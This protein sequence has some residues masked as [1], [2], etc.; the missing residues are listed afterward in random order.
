VPAAPVVIEDASGYHGEAERAFAPES[1][2]ELA[3]LLA[4]ASH[5]KIPVTVAGALTGVAGGAA[6]RGGWSISTS[7]LRHLD[8]RPGLAVVAAGV[9]LADLHAAASATGQI[10]GP[11][12]T[13]TTASLGGNAA[14]NASGSRSFRY[15]DTRRNTLAL[16]V[17]T[18]GGRP[19]EFRRGEPID[20]PVRSIPAPRTTKHAAGFPLA[21]GMDWVDLFIGSEGSLGVITALEVRLEPKPP[22]LLSGVVFF[23]TEEH[24]LD[25]VDLWRGVE[26]LRM[27][28]FLDAASL[29]MLETPAGAALLIE[30]E[31]EDEDGPEVDQWADRLA[32]AGASDSWIASSDRDRERLRR[33]RHA[34]PEAVN[35][36]VRRNGF[37]K[38]GSDCAVPLE[39]GRD[40]MRYYR[41][42]LRAEFAENAVVF[43]HIG[44]AHVHANVL[45]RSA[46]EFERGQ[47]LMLE[48]AREAV[49]R[50]GTVSAEHGLGKRK[51]HLLRIQYGEEDI[52][53]MREVK[54]RLDPQGLLAPGNLL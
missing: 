21:P 18:I 2:E 3:A 47:E 39:C 28:E 43:G 6:P 37:L 7:K 14:T 36:A 23:P 46:G 24:A 51:A 5:R 30:Q 49:A 10:Y 32:A 38:V 15:G 22:A 29:A 45:P 41:R 8:V 48:F 11:D 35:A 9:A 40:M 19:R 13:E 42:R 1:E 27:L 54:R 20:F 52:G 33:F 44:D 26:R 25:A 16:R 50:G 17:A 4:D 12:P 34:L 53:A 31:T